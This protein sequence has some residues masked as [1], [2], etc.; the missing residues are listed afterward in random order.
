MRTVVFGSMEI[1][2]LFS[3]G[4][5]TGLGGLGVGW[6]G[7]GKPGLFLSQVTV[8]IPVLSLSSATSETGL[9]F[10]KLPVLTA[11][12]GPEALPPHLSVIT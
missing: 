6:V 9:H 8:C 3:P 2:L 11:C 12:K 4:E 1:G 10:S 5:R 7:K